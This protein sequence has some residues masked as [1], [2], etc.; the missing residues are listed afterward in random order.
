MSEACKCREVPRSRS[1]GQQDEQDLLDVAYI[2]LGAMDALE[3]WPADGAV[4]D[5]F[6]GHL[7]F[8]Q[9]C[10]EHAP[11][12]H[13]L[14]LER[15]EQA[16]LAWCYDVAEPFG[17]RYGRHLLAGGEP[18]HAETILRDVLA[19]ALRPPTG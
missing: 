19:S 17:E 11:L 18:R 2:A 7:G 5:R 12:L 15:G 16:G 8:I 1:D 4:M 6:G 13:R 14:W 9:A 10:I 3:D